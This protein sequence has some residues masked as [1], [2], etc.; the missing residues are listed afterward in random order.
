[1]HTPQTQPTKIPEAY[2]ATEISA[3][4]KER[5]RIQSWI[6]A[7]VACAAIVSLLIVVVLVAYLAI[8]NRPT[9]YIEGV[10]QPLQPFLLP[11]IGAVVGYAL[12]ERER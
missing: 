6:G 4:I 12:G 9:D 11:V 3:H 8:D 10:I 7:S 1:M 2:G 5:F